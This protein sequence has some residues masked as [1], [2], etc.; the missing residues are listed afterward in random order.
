[1]QVRW[2]EPSASAA[3][4]GPLPA[5]LVV[6]RNDPAM[7]ENFQCEAEGLAALADAGAIRVPALLAVGVAGCRAYLVTELIE[8]S[9]SSDQDT[10]DDAHGKTVPRSDRSAVFG[11]QLAALH[12][13]TRGDAIGWTRDNFLGSAR[14]PNAPRPTWEAF[15]AE[16]RIGFQIRWA[17]DQRLADSE[18]RRDGEQIA[19]RMPDLLSGRDG[20]T[21]LLHGDLW[22]GNY[23]FDHRNRP[24][25]IDPAVYRGCREA[26]WGM[27][28]LFGG[29]DAAFRRGY[30]ETWAMPDGWQRRVDVY[31]LYHLLN[32]L[33]L[34]GSS[35][36]SGCRQR[37][38]RI[39]RA[40]V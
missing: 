21:S 3:A 35:Y 38:R 16:Q 9:P 7:L 27:I 14:Q 25:L 34:F 8:S 26:E 39:L 23:L 19:A 40:T 29:C 6:K 33:N 10:G 2:D 11:Q 32:H 18:L 24:V 36:L 37:A 17:V 13:A 22:S 20:T 12:R 1:V 28:E 15:V 30:Q 4:T 31:V 5:R